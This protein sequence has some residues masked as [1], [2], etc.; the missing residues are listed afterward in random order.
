MGK[1]T[2]SARKGIQG[3]YIEC[4]YNELRHGFVPGGNTQKQNALIKEARDAALRKWEFPVD[5][6]NRKRLLI[7][8]LPKPLIS[9]Y[10]RNRLKQL[11]KANTHK[12]Y[13]D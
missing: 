9:M 8:Y 1:Y 11:K 10:F 12:H 2:P 3:R 4:V 5:L 7:S 13:F 6:K